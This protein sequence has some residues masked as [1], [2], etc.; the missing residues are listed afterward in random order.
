MPGELFRLPMVDS[1][2]P[3]TRFVDLSMCPCFSTHMWVVLS[4]MYGKLV[5]LLT[6]AFCLTEVMDNSIL[7]LT[8][9]VRWN[10]TENHRR[11]RYH[12]TTFASY[13][14]R[15]LRALYAKPINTRSETKRYV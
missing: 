7:P 9:Q 10:T 12:L 4:S 6:I 14:E 5:V 2:S 3:K 8:F 11:T 15:R 13:A 1:S